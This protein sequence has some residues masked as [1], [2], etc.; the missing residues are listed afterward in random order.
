ELVGLWHAVAFDEEEDMQKMQK[1]GLTR[2]KTYRESGTSARGKEAISGSASIALFGNT[3]QPV[4]VM[5][6]S[7]PLFIPLPEVIREDMAFLDRIH[8]YLPGCDVP[9]MRIEDFI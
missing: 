7:S 9:K 4:E 6:R 5:V 3:N 2:L 8:F 1:E